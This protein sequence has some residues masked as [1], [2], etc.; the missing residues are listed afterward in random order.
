MYIGCLCASIRG[1]GTVV[2][3]RLI[4]QCV[5]DQPDWPDEN[6]SHPQLTEG[7]LAQTTSRDRS[8]CDNNEKT[9]EPF[10]SIF[11]AYPLC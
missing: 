11:S 2:V 5:F 3:R 1:L 8:R 6:Q 10:Q 9:L 7:Q 4:M